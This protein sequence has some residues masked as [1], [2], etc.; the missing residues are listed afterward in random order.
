M[1][2]ERFKL[3]FDENGYLQRY[4]KIRKRDIKGNLDCKNTQRYMKRVK[5]IEYDEVKLNNNSI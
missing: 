1:R 5:S 2:K 4:S 3:S